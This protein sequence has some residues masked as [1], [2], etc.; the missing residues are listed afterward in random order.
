MLRRRDFYQ[1]DPNPDLPHQLNLRWEGMKVVASCNCSHRIGTFR[2]ELEDV[3][4]G[5]KA[6]YDKHVDTVLKKQAELFPTRP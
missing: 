3:A 1:A 5:A 6:S 2:P 4:M